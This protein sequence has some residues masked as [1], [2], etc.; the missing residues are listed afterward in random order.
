MPPNSPCA[1]TR[2]PRPLGF[3]IALASLLGALACASAPV[4]TP[5]TAA[6]Q[7]NATQAMA[8]AAGYAQIDPARLESAQIVIRTTQ[9][10][11]AIDGEGLLQGQTA[12]HGNSFDILVVYYP[13]NGNL[14]CGTPLIHELYHVA[15]KLKTGNGD[16]GHTDHLWPQ[17]DEAEL[18]A[19][20]CGAP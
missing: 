14:A 4:G 20:L 6:L 10:E 11:N 19:Q 5:L 2:C 7:A 15:L 18:S 13:Q 9:H 3:S 12:D 17:V 8:I 1:A 16:A